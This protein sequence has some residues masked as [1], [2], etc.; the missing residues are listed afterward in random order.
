M[1]GVCRSQSGNSCSWTIWDPKIDGPLDESKVVEETINGKLL[2]GIYKL[3][4]R[5]G[6][7]EE[8]E[9][10]ELTVQHRTE[11]A[12]T[13]IDGPFAEERLAAKKKVILDGLEQASK[14]RAKN[15]VET[16]TPSAM[17]ML[18][19]LNAAA[20]GHDSTQP[21]QVFDHGDD[22]NASMIEMPESD[23][24]SE[25][26]EHQQHVQLSMIFGNPH[27]VAKARPTSSPV[28]SVGVRRT[29]DVAGGQ[30]KPTKNTV[31][32]AGARRTESLTQ[33]H[34]GTL[35]AV[36]REAVVLDGR[37]NRL[38]TSTAETIRQMRQDLACLSELDDPKFA[39]PSTKQAKDDLNAFL[40]ER[41]G[42]AQKLVA[43][44][45]KET[46]RIDK[47]K[48]AEMFE[49]ELADLRDIK[50]RTDACIGI[51]DVLPKP[52]SAP[53]DVLAAHATCERFGMKCST[54]F[55]RYEFWN[56]GQ[57][58]MVFND[59]TSLCKMCFSDSPEVV[60]LMQHGSSMEDC[61][62]L[63][64]ELLMDSVLVLM[65]T[66]FPSEKEAR[67]PAHTSNIKKQ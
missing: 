19:L 33:V 6:V 38:K 53:D 64:C 39:P 61:T 20:L 43:A 4:G 7:C 57:H 59:V 44:C 8:E 30:G 41:R 17:D 24:S 50:E 16:K 46:M 25:G 54:G 45:S 12:N 22:V 65:Q 55:Y 26:P 40:K 11:H 32:D 37:G 36:T 13:D 18:A 42:L 29:S 9:F 28:A 14:H 51:F 10:S 67:I 56:K 15:A 1:V 21:Q 31:S 52:N 47:S 60:K 34:A 27:S 2:K 5:E 23:D 63:A 49:D 35:P 62:Q 3:I 58:Y 48:S 66:A